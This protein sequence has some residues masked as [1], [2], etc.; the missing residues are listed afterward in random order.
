[1]NAN[2]ISGSC[3]EYDVIPSKPEN[4]A[5]CWYFVN[6]VKSRVEISQNFVAFSKYMNFISAV[7]L[8]YHTIWLAKDPLSANVTKRKEALIIVI[9]VVVQI[10]VFR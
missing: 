3:L 6:F 9:Q 4:R 7:V 1:M 10:F 2:A 5:R 8:L